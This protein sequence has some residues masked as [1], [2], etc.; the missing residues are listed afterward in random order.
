MTNKV[1]IIRGSGTDK[2][3]ARHADQIADFLAA[4]TSDIEIDTPHYARSADK[5]T[6]YLLELLKENEPKPDKYPEDMIVYITIA[7][8]RD[9]L[10][11]VV[12]THTSW[13]SIASR[14]DWNDENALRLYL[15][16][17][18]GVPKDT[19]YGCVLGPKA[20]FHYQDT[21]NF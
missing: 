11:G 14:P 21:P 5:L 13:P 3:D 1:I 19:P 4:A 8:M 10:S 12:S 20:Y 18:L 16:S 17:T 15:A 6:E 2:V 7:G 9:A